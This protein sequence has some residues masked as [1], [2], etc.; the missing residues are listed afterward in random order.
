MKWLPRED[1]KPYDLR[2]PCCLQSAHAQAPPLPPASF[3]S[4]VWASDLT[5]GHTEARD[6][7]QFKGSSLVQWPRGPSGHPQS[8]LAFEFW[9]PPGFQLRAEAPEV[10]GDGHP[11]TPR[12]ARG[13]SRLQRGPA[14]AGI[15]TWGVN[16]WLS[17]LCL[18]LKKKKT[19][20]N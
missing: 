2:G 4:H 18:L 19:N 7:L 20:K 5:S 1:V 17:E 6:P 8:M 12:E 3:R 11:V 14:L 10:A 13:S 15:D 16:Q 9:F